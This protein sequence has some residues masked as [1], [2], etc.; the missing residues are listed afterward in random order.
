MQ[1]VATATGGSGVSDLAAS[2]PPVSAE[3]METDEPR[4]GRSAAGGAASEVSKHWGGGG[5][6]HVRCL[7]LS[8]IR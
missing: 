2:S 8:T 5:D 1:K 6:V 4:V 7:F 3:V